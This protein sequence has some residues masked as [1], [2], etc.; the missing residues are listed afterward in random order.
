MSA[1]TSVTITSSYPFD[2]YK[3]C[4]VLEREGFETEVDPIGP[5]VIASVPAVSRDLSDFVHDLFWED[6][7]AVS[8]ETV[9]E[10]EGDR[11]R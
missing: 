2:P 9:T 10:E 3:V 6:C 11:M 4:E 7:W 8:D 1:K 5:V